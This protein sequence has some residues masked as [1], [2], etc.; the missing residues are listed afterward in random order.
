MQDGKDVDGTVETEMAALNGQPEAAPPVVVCFRSVS[1]RDSVYLSPSNPL[2]STLLGFIPHLY[3]TPSPA[4][5]WCTEMSSRK[6]PKPLP[7]FEIG[8]THRPVSIVRI[9]DLS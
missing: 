3:P 7:K 5:I 4:G 1:I 6:N 2:L 8:T 9:S